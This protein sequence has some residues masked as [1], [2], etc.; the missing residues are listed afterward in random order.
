M[1]NDEQYYNIIEDAAV[2]YRQ[3]Y[4]ILIEHFNELPEDIKVKV[5]AQL[6]VLGL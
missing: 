2:K 4:D 1:V 6:E 5:H 3:A